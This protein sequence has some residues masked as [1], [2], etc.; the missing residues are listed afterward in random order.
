[1]LCP[2]EWSVC[3]N[4]TIIYHTQNSPP[5]PFC[6]G[7]I[8]SISGLFQSTPS[9]GKATLPVEHHQELEY[10][11]QSTPSGGKA[12][13]RPSELRD[14][15]IVSIHAFRGEGDRASE[16]LRVPGRMFQS[17]PS[18]GKATCRALSLWLRF[19]GVSIHAFRGEGDRSPAAGR[20]GRTVSIHAF[21]GE[22]DVVVAVIG[23]LII[24]RFNPRLPG[25]RR[26][27]V[28]PTPQ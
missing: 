22:G 5:Y 11:F 3:R 18:G 23:I 8:F 1:M 25:G 20:E 9:G 14:V 28:A 6:S 16:T 15:S 17:T 4:D 21:R 13:R 7:L 12:T 27:T 26:L 19:S 2:P 24:K 10:Q